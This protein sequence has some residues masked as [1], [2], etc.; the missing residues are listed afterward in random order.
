MGA[1]AAKFRARRRSAATHTTPVAIR[2]FLTISSGAET[3]RASRK[4]VAPGKNGRRKRAHSAGVLCPQGAGAPPTG[5]RSRPQAPDPDVPYAAATRSAWRSRCT[6]HWSRWWS[7]RCARRPM[8]RA[9]RAAVVQLMFVT[10][11][12][13]RLR[14]WLAR[15]C[16]RAVVA[17]RVLVVCAVAEDVPAV[18]V[19]VLR[20]AIAQ[21]TRRRRFDT[22]RVH[23]ASVEPRNYALNIARPFSRTAGRHGA[24]TVRK[25]SHLNGRA[26]NVTG[27]RHA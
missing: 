11:R 1:E 27:L 9:R 13:G 16:S 14:R 7:G 15:W 3:Y 25:H 23:T 20:L 4:R 10:W 6:R 26:A 17:Q 21:E 2:R 5:G 24:Q 19:G 12:T 18:A 22:F 8:H